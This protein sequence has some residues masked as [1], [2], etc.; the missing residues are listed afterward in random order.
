M[1]SPSSTEPAQGAELYTKSIGAGLEWSKQI[2]TL[3]TGTLVLSG[4][5]IQ[6]FFENELVKKGWIL[7][8]WILMGISILFGVLYLGALCSLLVRAG[9]PNANVA[10]LTIYSRPAVWIALIHVFAFLLGLVA[11]I[12][13][14]FANL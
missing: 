9:E 1:T 14:V 10:N 13:F 6:M 12:I 5:F 11:F 4:T 7:A 2:T 3:A 8:S